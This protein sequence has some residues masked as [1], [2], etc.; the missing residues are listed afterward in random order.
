M[1]GTYLMENV[2]SREQFTVKIP[3]FQMEAPSKRN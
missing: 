3:V 2:H 1:F